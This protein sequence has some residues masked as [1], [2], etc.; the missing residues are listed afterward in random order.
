MTSYCTRSPTRTD[1]ILFFDR[2][3]DGSYADGWSGQ[4]VHGVDTSG[5]RRG[6]RRRARKKG[7]HLPDF[8]N[9][10]TYHWDWPSTALLKRTYELLFAKP[11]VEQNPE[12]FVALER[13]EFTKAFNVFCRTD[14]PLEDRQDY[15]IIRMLWWG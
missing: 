6:R 8:V 1:R 5:G 12:A 13:S 15:E 7:I 2:L 4:C 3:N 11:A 14:E 9:V 10:Y